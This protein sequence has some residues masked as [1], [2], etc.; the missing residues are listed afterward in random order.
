MSLATTVPTET[1][2]NTLIDDDSLY[3]IVNGER[4]EKPRMGNIQVWVASILA[5][6]LGHHARTNQFG[7]VVSEMLFKLN[8]PGSPQ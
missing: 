8:P 4:V 6:R 7:R 5:Q 2:P 1:I 3:E